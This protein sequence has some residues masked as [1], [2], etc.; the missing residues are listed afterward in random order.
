MK[1]KAINEELIIIAQLASFTG[2]T[3][4]AVK[5]IHV[6]AADLMN[7]M[8]IKHGFLASPPRVQINKDPQ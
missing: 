2:V 7:E 4:E 6:K 3:M 8:A 5:E 1:I